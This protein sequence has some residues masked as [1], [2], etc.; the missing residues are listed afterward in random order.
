M[1]NALPDLVLA[2]IFSFLS[3]TEKICTATLVCR[4]WYNVIH[5]STV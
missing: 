2:V 1:I 4:K 5:S 3:E